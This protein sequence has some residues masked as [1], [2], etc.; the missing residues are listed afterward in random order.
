MQT[1]VD[2]SHSAH[3]DMRGHT[4]GG[5][6]FGIGVLTAKSS[7]QMMDLRSSN[8]LEIIGNSEYLPYKI[9]YQ[10]FLEAQRYTTKR[11]ILQQANE[12]EEKMAKNRKNVIFKQFQTHRN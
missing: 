8:K 10:Y 11:I 12:A 9:W 7:K 6:T 1:Y 2:S 4:G 3:M 5:S